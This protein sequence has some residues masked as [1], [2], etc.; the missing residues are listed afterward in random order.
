MSSGVVVDDDVLLGA[1]GDTLVHVRDDDAV[2]DERG[3]GLLGEGAHLVVHGDGVGVG[4]WLW[5]SLVPA[6]RISSERGTTHELVFG[7]DGLHDQPDA[8]R[9][10]ELP[11]LLGVRLVRAREV[12]DEVYARRL[13]PAD[14]ICVIDVA[15]FPLRLAY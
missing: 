15:L 12:H 14:V 8:F 13:G 4:Y 5:Q 7:F 2:E 6:L 10:H 9:R 3:V 1:R 11:P